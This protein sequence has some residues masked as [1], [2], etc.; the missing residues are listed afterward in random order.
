M[1]GET[2]CVSSTPRLGSDKLRVFVHDQCPTPVREKF[3]LVRRIAGMGRSCRYRAAAI[4][5]STAFERIIVTTMSCALSLGMERT[6]MKCGSSRAVIRGW[7]RK[8]GGPKLH[9]PVTNW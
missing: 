2:K 9:L 7:R 1:V 5:A 8:R 4:I 3:C 6:I